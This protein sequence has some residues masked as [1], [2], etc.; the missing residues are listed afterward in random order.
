MKRKISAT[1][2]PLSWGRL[3]SSYTGSTNIAFTHDNSSYIDVNPT[4]STGRSASLTSVTTLND[5]NK[6]DKP[7]NYEDALKLSAPI[8]YSQLVQKET[9]Y[10]AKQ[11]NSLACISDTNKTPPAD[12]LNSEGGNHFGRDEINCQLDPQ[13]LEPL[14]CLPPK[15]SHLYHTPGSTHD[16]SLQSE[17]KTHNS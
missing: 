4:I 1:S 13:K 2:W 14:S 8:L 15:Y 9:S 11:T 3:D 17:S 5:L 7:P 12:K 6:T 16:L 10:D